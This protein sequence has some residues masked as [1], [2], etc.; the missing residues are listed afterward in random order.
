MDFIFP[1]Q[2]LSISPYANVKLPDFLDK[3]KKTNSI[4]LEIDMFASWKHKSLNLLKTDWYAIIR[5]IGLGILWSMYE[6]IRLHPLIS[7]LAF[8]QIHADVYFIYAC[9]KDW[10]WIEDIQLVNGMVN[11]VMCSAQQRSLEGKNFD[12]DL[13]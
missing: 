7:P 10:I 5:T 4:E 11:Q 1:N 12:I 2:K 6:N 3:A 13:I 9:L 8:Q